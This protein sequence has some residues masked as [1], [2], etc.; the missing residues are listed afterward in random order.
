MRF[1]LGT[2]NRQ[3]LTTAD[4]VPRYDEHNKP[5]SNESFLLL[6]RKTGNLA[7]T[8]GKHSVIRLHLGLS[9]SG[10]RGDRGFGVD[11]FDYH[12]EWAET[13]KESKRRNY[14]KT[15]L[16]GATVARISIDDQ[17]ESCVFPHAGCT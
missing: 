7:A 17:R 12:N 11:V 4:D 16:N 2:E 10:P 14:N 8:P 5:S 1:G 13:L 15:S 9:S 3:G 6:L